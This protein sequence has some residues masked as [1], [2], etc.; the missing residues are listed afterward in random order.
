MRRVL[1]TW[2]VS[3]GRSWAESPIAEFLSTSTPKSPSRSRTDGKSAGRPRRQRRA[4]AHT[5]EGR[6]HMAAV[7]LGPTWNHSY[8]R[9]LLHGATVVVTLTYSNDHH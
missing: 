5:H 6:V 3:W 7:E 8:T 1:V 2:K 4:K 9:P